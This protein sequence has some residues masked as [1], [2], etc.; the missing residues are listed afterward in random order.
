MSENPDPRVS[1]Q[2]QIEVIFE[3]WGRFIFRARWPALVLSLVVTGW[4]I[5]FLPGLT[6]DN[7]TEGLLLPDDPSVLAYN[8]FRDQ[9]GRD[10]TVIVA[11]EA[12]AIF[13]P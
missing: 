8:A 2:A 13:T 5:S 1:W 4:L 6:I 11:I 12:P 7:S 10:D 9:F 3:R